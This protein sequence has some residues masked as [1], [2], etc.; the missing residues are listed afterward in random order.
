M[1]VPFVI[2]LVTLAAYPS[3]TG[4]AGPAVVGA[5]VGGLPGGVGIGAHRLIRPIRR[6]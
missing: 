2:D 4:P 3:S 5:A 6:F 1:A